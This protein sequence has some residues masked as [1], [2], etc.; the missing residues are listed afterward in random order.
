MSAVPLAV[1]SFVTI[2][3]SPNYV[4]PGYSVFMASLATVLVLRFVNKDD[5]IYPDYGENPK[6]LGRFDWFS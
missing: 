2:I 3:S 6:N 4:F 5:I 1:Q